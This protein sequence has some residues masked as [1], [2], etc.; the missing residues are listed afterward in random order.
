[1]STVGRG[2]CEEKGE[3][4]TLRCVCVWSRGESVG[5]LK[6]KSAVVRLGGNM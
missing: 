6:N 5:A 3:N 1:M 2:A 4:S